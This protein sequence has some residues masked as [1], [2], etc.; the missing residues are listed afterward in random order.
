[1][2]ETVLDKIIFAIRNQPQGRN[3]VSRTAIAKYLK[4][5]MDFDNAKAVR[6]NLVKGV[7]SNK[8]VQTGQSFRVQGDDIAQVTPEE[9]VEIEDVKLGAEETASA[10]VGDTVCVK[11]EGKLKDGTIFDSAS[12]FEFSLGAGDVI[13]GEQIFLFRTDFFR[14]LHDVFIPF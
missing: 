4:S 6:L 7:K 2:T 3:G 13:K 10:S 9:T 12:S 11:Y 1:M 8:L 5:E 14:W